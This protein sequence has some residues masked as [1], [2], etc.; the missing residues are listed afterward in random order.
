MKLWDRI[1]HPKTCSTPV[2]GPVSTQP[3]SFYVSKVDGAWRVS[4]SDGV[5]QSVICSDLR[6]V[7]ELIDD[8]EYNYELARALLEERA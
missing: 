2:A 1:R 5:L 6:E 7:N 8:A 3:P 4:S